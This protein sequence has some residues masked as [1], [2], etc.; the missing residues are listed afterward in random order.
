MMYFCMYKQKNVILHARTGL[1]RFA[2]NA[3]E[4]LTNIDTN[5]DLESVVNKKNAVKNI[6]HFIA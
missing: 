6:I 2:D 3:R 4:F 5:T 1:I